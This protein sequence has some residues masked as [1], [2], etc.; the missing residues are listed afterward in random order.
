MV[1]AG[2]YKFLKSEHLNQI[3]TG[4]DLAK[5]HVHTLHA[6]SASV[7]MTYFSIV[8]LFKPLNHK[9]DQHP[10][11]LY[12]NTAESLTTIMRIKEMIIS[13]RSVDC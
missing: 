5:L 8:G 3:T 6:K 13:L 10:I 12:S 11:S 4:K 7:N 1:T 2:V 9:C